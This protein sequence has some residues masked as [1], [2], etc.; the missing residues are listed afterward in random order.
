MG[1]KNHIDSLLDNGGFKWHH[2]KP[3]FPQEYD[4]YY[5]L[6]TQTMFIYYNNGWTIFSATLTK[7]HE[8]YLKLKE[9]FDE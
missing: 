5:E 3:D 6:H 2:H 1:N 4:V 7:L 9:L 8:R